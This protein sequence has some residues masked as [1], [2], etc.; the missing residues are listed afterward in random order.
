MLSSGF[1]C[2]SPLPA[3][4]LEMLHQG[5]QHQWGQKQITYPAI[6]R[7]LSRELHGAILKIH[8]LFK[9]EFKNSN[10]KILIQKDTCIPVFIAA[11]FTVAKTWK[12]RKCPLTEEWIKKMWYMY[13]MQYYLAI[14]KN[15]TRP[16][17]ATWMDLEV[18]TL[19]QRKTGIIWYHLSVESKKIDTNEL[20]YR[21]ETDS[22][23]LKK[24]PYGYQRGKRGQRE[25]LG[26]WD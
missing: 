12:Q 13:T 10:L 26:V 20:I 19:S 17:A 5:N 7:R 11:L 14:K 24:K 23:T 6:E 16:F 25:K 9:L 18:F 22:Q 15:G 2:F 1:T 21:T 3:S 8:I 4:A